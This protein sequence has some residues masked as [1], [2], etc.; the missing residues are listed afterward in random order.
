[1]KELAATRG[2]DLLVVDSGDMHDGNGL[3]DGFPPG[4]V[5]GHEVSKRKASH[6][7]GIILIVTPAQTNK[8]FARMP[9]D[10]LAIGK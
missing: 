3:S 9:Y 8:I 4:G 7:R 10:A 5:N 2:A 1:M 6:V